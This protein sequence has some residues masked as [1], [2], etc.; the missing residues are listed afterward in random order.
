MDAS[1]K[2]YKSKTL[3]VAFILAGLSLIPGVKDF[4]SANPQMVMLISS[5]IFSGLRLISKGA[6]SFE[7]QDV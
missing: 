4:V 2:P 6:I 1:K 3:I 5:A 7:D